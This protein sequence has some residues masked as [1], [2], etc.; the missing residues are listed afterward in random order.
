MKLEFARLVN[1]R[2]FYGQQ[3][4]GF[5]TYKDL[6]VTVFHGDNGA[7]KS[8][9]F[10]AINWCLYGEGIEDIGEII[11]KRAIKEAPIGEE[12]TTSVQISFIHQGKMYVADRSITVKK[13]VDG[14]KKVDKEFTLTRIKKS[15][16][17]VKEDKPI[18]T[19]NAILPSNVRTYFFFDGEKMDDL[20]RAN[21]EDVTEAIRNIMRLPALERAQDHLNTVAAEFRREVA[22]QGSPELEKLTEEEEDLRKSKEKN[23]TR[24]DELEEEMHL[25]KE[26]LEEVENQLRDTQETRELQKERDELSREIE[27]LDKRDSELILDIQKTVSKTFVKYLPEIAEKAIGILDEKRE[28]GEIPSGVRET[29][30]KDLLEDLEC[31]CGRPFKEGDEAYKKLNS[32][33]KKATSSK[34][35]ME[36]SRL[37]GSLG[38]LSSRYEDDYSNLNTFVKHRAQTQEDNE[39]KYA[40][41][42]EIKHKI[43]NS[44]EEEI[45]NLEKLRT[46]IERDY[47]LCISNQGKVIGALE[48]IE[49]QISEIGN[50]REKALSK[51]KKVAFLSK[52]ERLSQQA[53]DAVA[54]IKEEFFEN[55]RMEIEKATKKVFSTL[56]WKQD[57]FQDLVLDENFRL[58]VI[59]RWGTPTRQELSAGERQ[60]LSLSF[61]TALSNLSGEEAPLVMDTPFGR[62]SGNHLSAVAENLPDLTPQLILFVTDR[63]WDEASRT[64][65]EPRVGTQYNLNFDIGN[66]C[67]TVEEIEFK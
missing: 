65:L 66:G 38:L 14:Y 27:S 54:I 61:I 17:H 48:V 35:E 52:K 33:L 28:K 20:T 60:I 6:N 51:E 46:K 23:L 47:R 67:T 56:A 64:N 34:L 30:V 21:S 57:H 12:V 7:G 31:I 41:L 58:E 59:D 44:S 5:S 45:A 2:Q 18:G 13:L 11:S 16:D 40:Q 29:V 22:K 3:D 19:M 10:S 9:F 63:E 62:L 53:A 49:K 50:R 1:Y 37:G 32:L 4:I 42:D 43:G 24:K 8:S 39:K 26:H 55:T 15:G 25:G 36:V